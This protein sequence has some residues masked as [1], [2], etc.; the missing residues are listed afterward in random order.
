MILSL[1]SCKEC[2]TEPEKVIPLNITAPYIES[3]IVWLRILSTDSTKIK[4]YTIIRDSIIISEGSFIGKDTI[5]ADR[6]VEPNTSY[7]YL[8]QY[9]DEV[10]DP[11]T[12]TTMD[13][14]SNNFTWE[15]FYF[16]D[17]TKDNL[18]KNVSIVD[19]NDIWVVGL[20]TVW[21]WDSL[22]SEYD[23]IRYNALHWDGI[24]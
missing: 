22:D 15:V 1:F 17:A 9:S 7:T 5:V 18:L 24:K 20:I 13:I 11:I 2:P 21:G 12:V 3:T 8:V 6:S 23:W 10:S 14:S 19:E 4:S 16:G